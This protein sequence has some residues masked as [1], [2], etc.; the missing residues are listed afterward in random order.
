MK[1]PE[2]W[3]CSKFPLWIGGQI[4]RPGW[5]GLRKASHAQIFFRS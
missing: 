1:G 5:G 2:A 3:L 4:P